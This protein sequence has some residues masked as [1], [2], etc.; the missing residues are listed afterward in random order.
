MDKLIASFTAQL[1]EALQI[2]SSFNFQHE[3]KP[4]QHVVISGLGGS[5]IGASIVQNYTSGSIKVPVVVNKNYFL[6]AFVNEHS[7]VIISSYSGNT[8]ETIQAFKDAQ[9]KKATIVCITS[10]GT[11]AKEAAKK[12]LDCI[13][14]P[15]GM[16]P[17]A[18]LS[19]S[20][21]QALY[22]L[23]RYGLIAK[24]FEK[25]LKNTISLLDA[26]E[27]SMKGQAKKL[28]RKMHGK[29]PVL[30]SAASL[31]GV[32]VRW[33][34][35]I[36]ENAK[37]LCWHNVVPEMNHNEIVGWKDK[38][39]DCAVIFLRSREDY[40]RTQMRIE[41]NKKMIRKSTSQCYELYAEGKSYLEQALYLVHIGDWLSWYLAAEH[42]V[43]PN[44]VKAID[45]L[46]GE[47]LK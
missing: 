31:E 28:A 43:D 40:E 15:P 35:Q 16:P 9:R 44:E 21:V 29:I 13:I 10:G 6:P 11:I 46:K 41:I 1:T 32:A 30:Y 12:K 27:K 47:L 19:Y 5:G 36:N 37:M 7:L 3:A 23:H 26:D 20:F 8:E 45:F 22:I 14:I 18:C 34:Q 38:R 2:G 17:R 39:D 24:T 33:R 25:D 4:V 42:S